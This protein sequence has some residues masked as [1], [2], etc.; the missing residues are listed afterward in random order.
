M[1]NNFEEN[2]SLYKRNTKQFQLIFFN[3]LKFQ[4]VVDFKKVKNQH[5]YYSYI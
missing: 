2:F 3:R 4:K 5:V 1:K